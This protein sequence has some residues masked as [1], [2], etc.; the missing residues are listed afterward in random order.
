VRAGGTVS[1]LCKMAVFTF[2]TLNLWFLV[3][4]SLVVAVISLVLTCL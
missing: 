3:V 1:G 2:A 4:K